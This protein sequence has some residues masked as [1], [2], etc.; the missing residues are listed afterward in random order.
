MDIRKIIALIVLLS[1]AILSAQAPAIQWQKCYGGIGV[2][3]AIC[4]RQTTDGGY[5]FAAWPIG[6]PVM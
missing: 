3:E 4:I 1:T 5:I 6:I 2:D